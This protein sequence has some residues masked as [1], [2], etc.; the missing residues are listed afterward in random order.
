M[1]VWWF[2]LG[3][4]TL[5]WWLVT[6]LKGQ[7]RWWVQAALAIP[8]GI[9]VVS[10]ASFLLAVVLQNTNYAIILTNSLLVIPLIWAGKQVMQRWRVRD[11]FTARFFAL[12]TGVLGLLV[13]FWFHSPYGNANGGLSINGYSWGDIPLHMTLASF[14]AHQVKPILELPLLPHTSLTYPFLIDWQAG[15][16]VNLGASWVFALAVPGALLCG[17]ALILSVE[18][19]KRLVGSVRA[20]GLHL[21]LFLGLGSAGGA[22]LLLKDIFAGHALWVTDYSNVLEQQLDLANPVTSHLF[23]QR[24]FLFGFACFVALFVIIYDLWK[25]ERWKTLVWPSIGL[26]LLI[27]AHVHSAVIGMAWWMGVACITMWQKPASRKWLGTGLGLMVLVALPQLWWIF[28]HLPAHFGSWYTGWMWNGEG[29]LVT[30]WLRQLGFDI[31][32]ILIGLYLMRKHYTNPFLVVGLLGGLALFITGNVRLFQPSGFDNLKFMLYGFWMLLVPAAYL[33]DKLSRSKLTLL[34]PLLVALCVLV[35]LHTIVREFTP[36]LSYEAFTSEDLLAA[37]DLQDVLPLDAVVAT[38]E[39]HNNMIAALVGRRV[40]AGY[41]GWLWSY[42]LNYQQTLTDEQTIMEGADDG[43]LATQY[44]VTFIA[45]H[46]RDEVDQQANLEALK[47]KYKVVYT[48][49]NW[50]VY[51]TQQL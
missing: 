29:N 17:S 30:Y 50:T 46:V 16:L 3:S 25:A 9:L 4:V 35:G 6:L 12:A 41:S 28:D 33:L 15:V 24:S 23:P 48:G 22:I 47:D 13:A 38:T 10:W 45:V 11:Q 19:V 43:T 34:T 39:H 26:G 44:G 20:G 40:L 5:G 8:V 7:W 49:H 14:F 1:I 51:S 32:L 27:F 21:T 2:L 42:G 37:D 36:D 18:L 31:P